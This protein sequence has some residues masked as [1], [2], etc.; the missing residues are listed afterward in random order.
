[1]TTQ[2]AKT[3]AQSFLQQIFGIALERPTSHQRSTPEVCR[4]DQPQQTTEMHAEVAFLAS[5]AHLPEEER[6]ARIELHE[7]YVQLAALRA[8]ADT[9]RSF[10]KFQETGD[11]RY[12]PWD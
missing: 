3:I 12:L 6:A 4:T 7:W 8:I 11:K 5:I 10:G 1:M 2:N 9:E